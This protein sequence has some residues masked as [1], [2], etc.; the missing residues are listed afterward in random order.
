MRSENNFFCVQKTLRQQKYLALLLLSTSYVMDKCCGR[1]NFIFKTSLPAFRL[2]G[3]KFREIL[4]TEEKDKHVLEEVS[5][6]FSRQLPGGM[7]WR[8]PLVQMD[9]E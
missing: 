3:F 6:F 8:S 7:D 5:N 1:N 4:E 9:F 2:P